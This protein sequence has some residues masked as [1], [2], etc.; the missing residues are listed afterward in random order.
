MTMRLGFVNLCTTVVYNH[1]FMTSLVDKMSEAK[2]TVQIGFINLCT[3]Y[4]SILSKFLKHRGK[5][6]FFVLYTKDL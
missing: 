2:M 5:A 3:A 4:S 6:N 1:N